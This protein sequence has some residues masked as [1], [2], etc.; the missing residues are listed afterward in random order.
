MMVGS[1]LPSP[2]DARRR[3]S[4]D[5]VVLELR[6]GHRGDAR[7]PRRRRRRRPRRPRGRGRRASPASRATARRS[8]S[9]PSW[10]CAR[11]AAGAVR[12]GGDDITGWSTRAPPRGRRRLHPRGPAPPGHAA[13]RDALGE[14]DPR[15]PDAAARRPRAG[16]S[17]ARPP[18]PTP[19]G[20]CK[21]LRR[22]CPGPDTLA[23]ALSGGNQ[24]KLIVGRE[25][26]SGAAAAGRRPPDPR[27]GRRRPGRDLGAA[28]GRPRRRD[29]HPA[30]LR[31]PRR[32]DRPVGHAAR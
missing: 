32:A 21:R 26:E 23:V 11:S 9:T 6:R 14:P 29:G 28:Q 7:R 5:T 31:R 4:R 19:S 3:P 10:A 15:S 16:S 30:D 20:S 8:W 25:M 2:G 1:E 12:L 17:T 27:R 22:P 18:A 13:G 24:Q